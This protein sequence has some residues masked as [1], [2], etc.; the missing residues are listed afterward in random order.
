MPIGINLE[1]LYPEDQIAREATNTFLLNLISSIAIVIVVIMVVM[2][3]RAGVLIGSSLL[4]SI[5]ATLL[6][7]LFVGEGLNRTS[8]AGFIIAMGMLVDNAI[9][10]VDNAQ[11][12]IARGVARYDAVVRGADAPKWSLLGAT[13]IAIFSFLP[14]YLAPSAVAEIVKPLFIVL[15]ISLLM[16]WVLA[17]I[18][19]PLFGLFGF[20]KGQQMVAPVTFLDYGI[21][22]LIL[23]NANPYFAPYEYVWD[24]DTF[25]L[26]SDFS[27]RTYGAALYHEST[28]ELAHWRFSA[29]I[30]LDYERAKL[31]YHN[32]TTTS[33]TCYDSSGDVVALRAID[34]DLRDKSSLS[35][36]E[37]LPRFTALYRVGRSRQSSL[38]ASIAKGYKAG[39]YNTQMFSDILQQ[40]VMKEFGVTIGEEYTI[41]RVISYDPEY[42]WN[43]EVGG[44]FE[45][46]T[47][48]IM[49]DVALFYIDCRNQQLTVFPEGQTTGRMMTNAGRSRSFGAE[50]SVRY[51]PTAA[52]L[53]DVSYGY[54][55]AK[56]VDYTSGLDDYA[57]NYVPYSP[58]HTL[59]GSVSYTLHLGAGFVEG[60]VF[61]LGARAL[62]RIYWNEENT[63]YQP[64]YGLLDG[65]VRVNMGRC[66]VT[67]W[68]RNLTGTDYNQFYFSSIG[69][70]FVQCGKPRTLGLRLT[71]TL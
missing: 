71:L 26:N 41:D 46:S 32:Y 70:E 24:D 2:G 35:F 23:A 29:G 37:V 36:F 55:N 65:S 58:Q 48:R 13:L 8:L 39:G 12:A 34:I 59:S 9:V 10:V 47:R 20:Y 42:S 28:Y 18:Q 11:N 17:L 1:V 53:A 68:G 31:T 60:V 15:A 67:L 56:F 43:Y 5:G 54:T 66:G 64:L 38:Y 25:A 45:S 44:H 19:T 50:L 21:E 63:R 16:S 14:L 40:R 52:L 30:R 6:I 7:M 3:V 69:N 51:T 49:H 33:A 62:G 61:D 57:G 4:F 22:Q 27:V